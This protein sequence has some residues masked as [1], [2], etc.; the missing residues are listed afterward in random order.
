M[1]LEDSPQVNQ[2]VRLVRQKGAAF[3]FGC[4][5]SEVE[6]MIARAKQLSPNKPCRVV[7]GWSWGDL[8]IDSQLAEKFR[9]EGIQPSFVF[10]NTIIFDEADPWD[11]GLCIKTTFLKYFYDPCIFVT[12]N[13]TYVLVGPGVRLTVLPEVYTELKLD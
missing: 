3:D 2:Y 13:T 7:S 11:A 8:D 5:E 4:N 9:Q 1:A 12:R 6:E 10:A